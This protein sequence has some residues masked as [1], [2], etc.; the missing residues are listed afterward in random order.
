MI[1]STQMNFL[2]ILSLIISVIVGYFIFVPE[3]LKPKSSSRSLDSHRISEVMLY[4]VLAAFIFL[5]M[6]LQTAVSNFF[7]L[8]PS[9]NYDQY[10]LMLEGN[11]VSYFQS[12]ATPTL[13]YFSVAIYLLGF[14]FLMIFTFVVLLCTQNSR[15]L[16]EYAIAFTIIY[17]TAYPFYIFFPVDVTGHVIPGMVPLLYQMNPAFL[18][19]A[20]ICSPRLDN[21]FPS[22]HAALSVMATLFVL[23][24]TNLRLYKIFA[25]G[26][27]I[28][29]FFAILYLGIHWITDLIGGIILA[30]MS[31]FIATQIS[32][33]RF[34]DEDIHLFMR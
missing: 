18:R 26:T 11:K 32:N 10:M 29:I 21:C 14:S 4:A 33:A 17:L 5:L 7:G 13:T 16:K 8:S 19:L 22:L 24:K 3:P 27:T 1:S 30:F 15:A 20:M 2:L 12:L 31:Y 25:V 9:R 28:L 6:N 23:F 34:K